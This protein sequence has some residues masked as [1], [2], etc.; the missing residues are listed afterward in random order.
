M[1]RK[2]NFPVLRINI[3]RAIPKLKYSK[4]NQIF[5]LYINILLLISSLMTIQFKM[6]VYQKI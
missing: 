2:V 3:F 6:I 4:L 1:I 5:Y